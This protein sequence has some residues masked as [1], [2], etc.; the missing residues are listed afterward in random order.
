MVIL[1]QIADHSG[2]YEDSFVFKLT[3]KDENRSSNNIMKFIKEK[4]SDEKENAKKEEEEKWTQRKEK[5]DMRK[6][7]KEKQEKRIRKDLHSRKKTG[8]PTAFKC[9]A[10]EKKKEKWGKEERKREKKSNLHSRK[11]TGQPT[12]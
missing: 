2:K 3:F 8:Q 12:A 5:G 4:K 11:K 10:K 7:G 9:K 1:K 6:R